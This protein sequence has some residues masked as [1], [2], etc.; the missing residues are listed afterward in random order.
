MPHV[1]PNLDVLIPGVSLNDSAL[2]DFRN[3]LLL[4]SDGLSLENDLFDEEYSVLVL[5]SHSIQLF[6]FKLL[7]LFPPLLPDVHL[8]I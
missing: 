5:Q 8:L 6:L 3:L 1:L 4:L 2:V 7:L